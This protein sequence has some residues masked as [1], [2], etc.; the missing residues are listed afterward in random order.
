MPPR[1]E[2]FRLRADAM[3]GMSR[4]LV[5]RFALTV[6]AAALLVVAAFASGLR[7]EGGGAGPLLVG[8]GLLSL[9]ALWSFRRRTARFR[10]RWATFT[11]TLDDGAVARTVEGFPEVRIGR[12]EVASIGEAPAGL[13]VRSR[14][15]PALVVPR[16]IEQYERI[17]D[18]LL[19]WRAG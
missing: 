17:R 3:S 14:A 6:A 16:E 5:R 4:R 8:L 7:G 11:V 12:G 2:R 19:R 10:A 13:V 15:G 1:A 18:A 9:L